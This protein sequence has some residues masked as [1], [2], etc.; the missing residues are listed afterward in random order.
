MKAYLLM[1]GVSDVS[2]AATGKVSRKQLRERAVELAALEGRAPQDA[3]KSDWEMAKQEL[4]GEP[5]QEPEPKAPRDND[6]PN[7]SG[8]TDPVKAFKPGWLS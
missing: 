7:E 3:G 2:P 6:T 4:S 1:E 8:L 5:E